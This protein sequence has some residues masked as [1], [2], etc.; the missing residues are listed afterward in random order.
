[1]R[2]ILS[3]LLVCLLLTA[4]ATTYY[5]SSTTGDDART[6]AQAQ[7]QATPWKTLAKLNSIFSTLN[8][9][10][11]ILFQR[12]NVFSG[13]IGAIK[14]GS[15]SLPITFGAYG[16]GAKPIISGLTTLSNWVSTGNGVWESYNPA[17]GS[18]V[19][20]V[21]LNNAVQQMGRYPNAN[22][23]NKGYLIYES[24]STLSIT[25]NELTSS[26]NWTGAEVVIRKLYWIMDRNLITAHSGGKLTFVS[27][28]GYS[29][30]QD[31]FGYFIQNDVRTLDQFGEWYFN[32]STKKLYVYFGGNAPTNYV[33][34]ASTRDHLVTNTY[35][36]SNIVFDNL[37]FKGS[38][39][40]AIKLDNTSNFSF[41]SCDVLFSGVDAIKCVNSINFKLENS[42][43][44]NSNNNGVSLEYANTNAVIRN[45]KIENTHTIAGMGKSGDGNGIGI[46]V[47][48]PGNLVEYN[49]VLNTGYIGIFFSGNSVIIKNNHINNFCISKDDGSGIYT[50]TEPNEASFTGRKVTGNVIVNGKGTPEGLAEGI[51]HAHGIY[52]DGLTTGL[53]VSGNTVANN[54]SYGIFCPNPKNTTINNNTLFNNRDQFVM[55][56]SIANYG[57]SNNVVTNNIFL[58]KR[59]TQMT[60]AI[61]SIGNDISGF[62][63]FDNN[64]YARPFDDKVSIFNQYVGSSGTVSETYDLDTWKA[65]Y[66]K[67]A[68]SKRSPVQFP[69][70]LVNSLIGSNKFNNGAFTSNVNGVGGWSAINNIVLSHTTGQLDG[71]SLQ[72]AFNSASGTPGSSLITMNIGALSSSKKYVLKFSLKGNNDNFSLGAYIRRNGADYYPITSSQFSKISTTRT[73]NELLFTV[74]TN[75]ANSDLVFTIDNQNI[76]FWLDN[77]QL[78][79]ADV[80]ITN[81]DDYIRFEYNPTNSNKS[82]GLDKNYIDVKNTSYSGTVTLAPYSSLILLKAG[83][84]TPTTDNTPPTII[85]LNVSI[86]ADASGQARI[87]PSDVISSIT[88]ASGVDN[89]SITLSQ[90]VFNCASG[91]GSPGS[92][93][94]YIAT[95]TTGTQ[96]FGGELGMEFT[97]NTSSGI[98]INQ[99]GAFDHQ[100]NGI[101]GTQSG[102]IRVAIFN[103]ATRTIVPG[104]DAIIIGNADAY[105]GNHRMKNIPAVTLMPGNYVVVAK[106]YNSNEMNGN[107]EARSPFPA[108]DLG[109]GAI[110]YA[111]ACLYGSVGT[112]FAYPTNPD[113]GPGNRYLAGS[114]SYST[115]GT[116]RQAYTAPTTTGTQNFGGELGMEFSVNNSSGIVINQLGAF[117]HQGNGISGTQSGGIRVA[118]FNKS[119]RA[120]VPGLNVVIIGNADSYV[121]NHRM[122]NV[123]PVTLTPGSY[124]VVAKGYNSTEMNGNAGWGTPFPVGDLGGG[125][126]SYAGSCMY[127]SE[128]SGFSYPTNPDGGPGNRYLAGSFM[129]STSSGGGSRGSSYPVTITAKDIHGNIGQ[130]TANVNV[131]C[132]Q[133]RVAMTPPPQAMT[134][135]Q[136]IIESV[137][138]ENVKIF[139]NP[140]TGKF[141]VQLNGNFGEKASVL[142]LNESG[143]TIESKY[144]NLVGQ[145]STS[146]LDFDLSARPGGTYFIRV[147]TAKGVQVLKIVKLH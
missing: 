19:N 18:S 74:P 20:M 17:L 4:N 45:N 36:V 93:Q 26:T 137:G 71:G 136:S 122:K 75:E 64:Y 15:A 63:S 133:L 70:F 54:A 86:T 76:R 144:I 119:T 68:S 77:I 29:P 134:E 13:S 9:G 79:E 78:Y 109:G 97:V 51:A 84:Q 62:G 6:A 58:S 52:L 21:L 60:M 124:V 47:V 43:V 85:P 69:A 44:A 114:F 34:E 147:L 129:Y 80:T 135:S 90:S 57:V 131:T 115:G 88:D 104:L 12:G 14:S 111:S 141:S 127:G 27:G 116:P 117:D 48:G 11:V 113:G 118:I 87:Q 103:K 106:G 30:H 49:E 65:K 16:S 3:F 46:Q 92:H 146:K 59:A 107:S 139:P 102:G 7:N 1:M 95:T 94:A 126:I 110:S 91:A 42:Y 61:S 25:D 40:N 140:T 143:L 56:H 41:R 130:A 38:N 50:N 81:P 32:P 145:N 142:M 24:H 98:V 67:D 23:A 66:G 31:K 35:N 5:F 10:D 99:L 108:G 105:T 2:V 89:S 53:E 138:T 28:S 121:G 82:V 112:G 55:N 73:E 120:I 125:A 100:G 33:V 8:P 123:T 96:N 128:G 72:V 37:T 101:S 39:S 132:P 83:S 22:A